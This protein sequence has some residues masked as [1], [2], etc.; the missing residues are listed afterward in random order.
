MSK[1]WEEW[2]YVPKEQAV[3]VLK[4]IE[5]QLTTKFGEL[6]DEKYN[7]NTKGYDYEEIVR[8]FYED[9][10]GG[11]FEVLIRMGI[12]DVE[13]KALSVLKPTENEFDIV[14][15]YKNAVPKLVHR[16][17]VPYDSVAFII[18]VKQTL[19]TTSLEEDLSKFAKLK[20]LKVNKERFNFSCWFPQNTIKRPIRVLF[21]YEKQADIEKVWQLLESF[22]AWDLCVILKENVVYTNSTIPFVE[23]SFRGS[24]F[25]QSPN[26][27]LVKTLLF[28]VAFIDRD[29]VSSWLIFWNL[30]RSTMEKDGS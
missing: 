7:P 19:T 4:R 18:E 12:L 28:T 17:L 10:V 29:Y 22:D 5:E 20:D 15:L 8:Q 23:K 14:G 9:Y 1:P 25:A 24:K 30:I 6:R 16:R 3:E 11:G 27:A 2:E 21:Y 26:F 13:L